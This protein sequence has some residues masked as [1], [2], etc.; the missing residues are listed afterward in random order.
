MDQ[1][2]K[3]IDMHIHTNYS[4]GVFSPKEVVEYANK[5]NLLAISITDHDCVDGI[6]EA[7]RAAKKCNIE[8][9][10]GIEL[11]CQVETNL[12]KNEMHILGYFID[13][14][15]QKLQNV[16]ATFKQARYDRALTMLD[17]LKE[18]N[19]VLKDKSFIQNAQNQSI[20]R[21]HFA[22]ALVMEGFVGSVQEAFQRYL[23]YDKP[24]YV[25][26]HYM[27]AIEAIELILS[28]GGLPIMAHPFHMHYNDK[29]VLKDLVDNGLA[30][31]EVW[32]V[33]HTDSL[34]KKFLELAKEF[35]LLV[36]GGSDCHGPFKKDIPIMGRIKVPY[37]VLDDLKVANQKRSN[38]LN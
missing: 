15:S 37:Y 26:K 13:Y 19:I 25:P 28:V 16:L 8:V 14:K 24:A 5:M 29:A 36:T 2:N 18:H 7:L 35:N 4:D 22:K 34:V 6:D 27:S 23:S 1:D 33:K 31:M 32:H 10:P 3:F 30:G 9:I 12:Q 21:L 38:K 20:G 17:K 11:S